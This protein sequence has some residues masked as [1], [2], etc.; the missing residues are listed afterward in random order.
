MKVMLMTKPT[1]QTKHYMLYYC[2]CAVKENMNGI[3]IEKKMNGPD[4]IMIVF[5]LVCCVF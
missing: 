5:E 3:G 1:K 4:K 2:V